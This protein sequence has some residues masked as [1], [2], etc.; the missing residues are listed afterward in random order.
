MARAK[1]QKPVE[2][3]TEL[4][5][6]V[7]GLQEIE[8]TEIEAQLET[9]S[10]IELLEGDEECDPLKDEEKDSKSKSKTQ[11]PLLDQTEKSQEN[12]SLQDSSEPEPSEL[13][14]QP[15][16]NLKGNGVK[17]VKAQAQKIIQV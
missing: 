11:E 1:K 16:N 8:V 15:S 13:E 9:E 12:L 10:K 3:V 5:Q 6:E 2:D 4:G 7:E 17:S 14:E